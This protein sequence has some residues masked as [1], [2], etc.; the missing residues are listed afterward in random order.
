MRVISFHSYKGGRGRTTAI[1]SIGN[2]YARMGK[3]VVLLDADVTAPWLHTRY[4]I[5]AETLDSKGWLRG[6]LKE[7][8]A[9]PA[10]VVPKADLDNYSVGIEGL[11]HG[12]VR[13]LA[14]GNPETEDYWRWMAE[15]FPRFLGVRADPHI[16]ESW[17][18]LRAL[19]ASASPRPDVLLV[20]APAGY[21][22]ASAYVAMAIADTAVLFAQADHADAAW[23]T[24]MVKM[25]R[26]ARPRDAAERYGELS[27]I[28]VRARYP[29]Y[30]YADFD[31]EDRFLS[32]QERYAEAKFDKW[33][34]LE[35]DPRLELTNLEAPIGLIE[36]IRRTRLVEGY[37]ELLSVALGY[38]PSHGGVLL[39]SLP[40]G[41]IVPGE[42]PQFF[43]L[44]ERGILTNPADA[45]RNVSFRVETFCGLLD[46]LHK[47]LIASTSGEAT[48]DPATAQPALRVAGR[49]PGKKFGKS[50]SEQLM[51]LVSIQ[52]DEAR[53]GRWC[54]FDS[55][56]GFGGLELRQIEQN[57]DGDARAGAI[58]VAG[59]FL[60]AKRTVDDHPLDLCALLTGYIEGVLSMLLGSKPSNISVNHP[61]DRCM[62]VH[63]ERSSC[64][65]DFSVPGDVAPAAK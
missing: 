54:E 33:V 27:V 13:L 63:P 18:D 1:T 48:D 57:S 59:N 50:L 15:E 20:D 4:D 21:H 37:A 36:P 6:L 12:S 19:I 62:R 28:G 60:A 25:M 3:H 17:R 22:Q 43:L 9:T 11:E 44:E 42:R 58:A 26:A 34:S 8:T 31:A 16:I 45:V 7:I 10:S 41:E 14:P 46:D 40:A 23:T 61:P 5:S 55:R 56:V 65:F 53:I 51:Q 32:Y 35:S 47:E 29:D 24:R 38:E 64:E 49:A 2:L 39:D 30:V 52:D